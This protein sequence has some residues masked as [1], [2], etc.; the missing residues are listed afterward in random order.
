LNPTG[1]TVE[2]YW[3][4]GRTLPALRSNPTGST[5]EPYRLYGFAL[6]A[7]RFCP[8]SVSVPSVWWKDTDT[9]HQTLGTLRQNFNL[10]LCS[11]VAHKLFLWPT[12]QGY[13]RAHSVNPLRHAHYVARGLTGSAG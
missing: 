5:V 6:P 2:P 13:R 9:G 12:L 1:S 11:L 3:L 7:L 10:K 4:Y 8:Y